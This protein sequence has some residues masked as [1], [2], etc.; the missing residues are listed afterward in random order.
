MLFADMAFSVHDGGVSI[1]ARR[2]VFLQK[3]TLTGTPGL[4]RESTI[5]IRLCS[6]SFAEKKTNQKKPP[7]SQG[8]PAAA[9]LG[10]G[11]WVIKR[12]PK[13]A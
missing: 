7:A 3:G 2:A 4:G 11:R 13:N 8:P 6:F 10:P 1:L 12:R 9:M 5:P